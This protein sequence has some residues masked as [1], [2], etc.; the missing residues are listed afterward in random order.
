[1]VGAPVRVFRRDIAGFNRGGLHAGKRLNGAV[2]SP[3]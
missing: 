2:G 1:M 3:R